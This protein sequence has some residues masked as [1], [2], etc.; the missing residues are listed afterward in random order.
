MNA[1]VASR[2]PE[3]S[4]FHF[5]LLQSKTTQPRLSTLDS[6]VRFFVLRITI[7]M[8]LSKLCRRNIGRLLSAG[9]LE[10]KAGAK[11]YLVSFLGSRIDDP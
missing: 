11:I 10:A 8:E 2:L 6:S 1:S 5:H 4:T 3:L 7:T 9:C